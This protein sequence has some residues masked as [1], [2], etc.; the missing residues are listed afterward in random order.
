VSPPVG[1]F[2]DVGGL[3]LFV[4]RRGDGGPPVVFLPGAGLVGLDYLHL[5]ERAAASRASLVY[6]RAGTGWSDDVRLP[7]TSTAVTDELHAVLATAAPGPAVLV[8]HSLGGLFARHYATRFPDAT[9]GLV[10]LDPAHE[11]YDAAMPAELKQTRAVTRMFDALTAVI[12]LAMKTSPGTALLRMAPPVRRYRRLYRDLFEQELSA[13]PADIRSVLVERHAGLD[14]LAV[15]LRESRRVERLY[16]EMRRA[17]P[18]PDVPL[19]I[20][21]S[22]G[23]DAFRDAVSSGDAQDLVHAEVDAK[24]KLYSTMA[25]S[26][27]RGEVRTVDSG[28]VTLPFRQPDAIVDAID[29]A[30]RADPVG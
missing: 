20:L 5:H 3:R 9:A 24:L 10:L 23:S 21:S 13:W 12:D 11:D 7:R 26:V 18:L 15:G 17:G 25:A 27:S 8:G 29:D 14:W 6:D 4:D 30:A 1:T 28:H 16:G 2:V 19:I 22:T